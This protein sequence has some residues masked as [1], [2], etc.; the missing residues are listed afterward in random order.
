MQNRIQGSFDD[1]VAG[2]TELGATTPAASA[3]KL[4]IPR[5]SLLQGQRECENAVD[6]Q[7]S[8]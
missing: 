8:A 1:A 2:G 4:P 6:L 7:P 5:A 3:P